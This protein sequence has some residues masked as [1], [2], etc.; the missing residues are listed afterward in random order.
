M[1][2]QKTAKNQDKIKTFIFTQL[3]VKSFKLNWV[4]IC[5]LQNVEHYA[6][7]QVLFKRA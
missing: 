1:S 5:K 6:K 2:K 4:Q 7:M 3:V